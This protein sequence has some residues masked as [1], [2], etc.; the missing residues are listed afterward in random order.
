MVTDSGVAKDSRE[1]IECFYQEPR[2]AQPDKDFISSLHGNIVE[3]PHS[4]HLIDETTLVFGVHLYR[5]IWADA[6]QKSLPGMFVGTGW[7]VWEQ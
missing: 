3:S 2:F 4:Y 1:N 7:D 6:L 5:D